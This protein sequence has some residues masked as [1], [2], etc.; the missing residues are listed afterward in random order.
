METKNNCP[1]CEERERQEKEHEDASFAVLVSIVPLLVLTFF[2][3]I[4]IL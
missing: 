1:H 4:G 2:S 3:Q